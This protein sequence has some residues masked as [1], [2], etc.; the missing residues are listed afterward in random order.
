LSL[1]QLLEESVDDVFDGVAGLF[2]D[3]LERGVDNMVGHLTSSLANRRGRGSPPFVRL[4]RCC[5]KWLLER[6]NL[7]GQGGSEVEELEA[8]VKDFVEVCGT[9]LSTAGDERIAARSAGRKKLFGLIERRQIQ[10]YLREMNPTFPTQCRTKLQK[11][12]KCAAPLVGAEAVEALRRLASAHF[13]TEEEE[14][15][16]RAHLTRQLGEDFILGNAPEGENSLFHSLAQF[17]RGRRQV[18]EDTDANEM[19][20]LLGQVV[21]ERHQAQL[22]AERFVGQW[23]PVLGHVAVEKWTEDVLKP[24][25]HGDAVAL[26]AF[27]NHYR[28]NL[29]LYSPEFPKGPVAFPFRADGGTFPGGCLQLAHVPWLSGGRGFVPVWP[30]GVTFTPVL[31]EVRTHTS[32][33]PLSSSAIHVLLI[34]KVSPPA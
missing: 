14:E 9:V 22:E 1:L 19:R 23:E 30:R 31:D 12:S 33:P 25:V 7:R 24:D 32:A 8:L 18:Q 29:R 21:A 6:H 11:T 5:F 15:D 3:K 17:S 13:V 26:D 2:C 4:Y 20:Q 16:A 28:I 27:A 10:R 34:A